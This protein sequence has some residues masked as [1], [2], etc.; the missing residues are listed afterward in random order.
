LLWKANGN[1]GTGLERVIVSEYLD[2]F[3]LD[4]P[5]AI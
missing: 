3:T 2:S 5:I 4:I 1:V